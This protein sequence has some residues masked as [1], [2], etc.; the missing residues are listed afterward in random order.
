MGWFSD[1]MEDLDRPANA[2]Q[3]YFVGAKRDDETRFEGL[4]RGWNQEENYDF[5]QLVSE[6]LAKQKFSERD[7]LGK[8]SY[9]LTG[10][11]NLLVDPLN[12][13]GGGMFTKG[14]K[15]VDDAIKAGAD[16]NP[17]AMKGFTAS[18]IPNFIQGY[19]GKTQRTVDVVEAMKQGLL[20]DSMKFT[21]PFQKQVLM[22]A[23][24]VIRSS[25]NI[26]RYEAGKKLTGFMK[27]GAYGGMNLLSNAL[28]PYSRA[29]YRSEGINKG[30]LEG[31][32]LSHKNDKNIEL[33][34]RALA[35]AH[36]LEQSGIVG[37]K[38]ILSDFNKFLGVRGYQPFKK[39]Q[40]GKLTK[41]MTA[42]LGGVPT[43]QEYSFIEKHIGS[44]WKD[45]KGIPF[46]DSK[47]TKLYI[48]RGGFEDRGRGM[49]K[50]GRHYDDVLGGLDAR[51]NAMQRTLT[52]ANPKNL[53]ELKKLLEGADYRGN[54]KPIFK[55][56]KESGNVWTNYGLKGSSITEGG[57]N[58]IVGVKPNGKFIMSV[59]DEHNFLEKIPGMSKLLPNRVLAVTPP[60]VGDIRNPVKKLTPLAN[61][62]LKRRVQDQDKFNWAEQLTELQYALPKSADLAYE[63]ARQ[64]AGVGAGLMSVPQ[65]QGNN[66]ND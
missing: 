27:T 43:K 21:T 44:V 18:S 16:V 65:Y 41:G 64:Q 59:S 63:K 60:F 66:S 38:Q 8:A 40:Y 10:T 15:G 3:G 32:F 20:T 52:D 22:Q 2:I 1:L 33:V 48:K 4:K 50:S 13:I 37:G 47:G 14:V 34:H 29:L 46:K 51:F 17:D 39:G 45:G 5:E 25:S 56:D 55:I 26:R 12:L 61:A 31:S 19:Y 11:A 28:S 6:D 53:K 49:N 42:G 58:V 30:L 62:T 9:L 36:I 24:D 35:N 54:S 23:D 7:A 57:V